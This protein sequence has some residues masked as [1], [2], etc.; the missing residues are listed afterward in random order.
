MKRVFI[1]I[2]LILFLGGPP[3]PAQDINLTG[4][5]LTFDDEFNSLSVTTAS[6]K[7]SATWYYLPPY[8]AAGYYSESQWDAAAFSVNGGIL[9]D[10]AFLDSSNNWHSGN[11]SSMDPTEAGFAQQYGYFEIRCQ[12]P[13]S[14]TGAW[15]A[16]WLTGKGSIQGNGQNNEEIDIFEWYGVC[17]TAGSYQ[18]FVQ[19]ASHNYLAN[20][21]QTGGLYSPQTPMPDGS[22][23]WQGYHIYGCQIDPV[24][25]TWY[26]DG[27]RTN[28]IA[29]PTSYITSPFYMMIDYALGGG[30]PLSGM[31]N[32]SSLNVDWVRVYA[33]PT[34]TVNADVPLPPW[35]T[36]AVAAGLLLVATRVLGRSAAESVRGARVG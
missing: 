6:P 2:G 9:S 7:G 30:W 31:V 15:P 17:N 28:Q 12:M 16:F 33:L 8:G 13:N 35:V 11:L 24:N 5:T 36:F 25:V 10:E 34:G 20:G 23:P 4:Y 19:Q 3:L 29:T 27:V 21:S 14:G 18:D 26:I 32:G 22:Y 1:P